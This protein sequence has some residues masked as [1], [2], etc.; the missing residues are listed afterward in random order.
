MLL[1]AVI[2]ATAAAAPHTSYPEPTLPSGWVDH[3]SEAM[4]RDAASVVKV[5]LAVREQNM[6]QIREI[7]LDVSNP[8]SPTYGHYLSQAQVDEITAPLRRMSLRSGRGS[9]PSSSRA[10]WRRPRPAASSS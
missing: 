5:T 1:L 2:A 8:D 9:P 6:D 7:A 10:M 3:F 4:G